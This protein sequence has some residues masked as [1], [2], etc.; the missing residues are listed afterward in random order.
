MSGLATAVE[1]FGWVALFFTI[2]VPASLA[3][4]WAGEFVTN[5]QIV[6]VGRGLFASVPVC[7]VGIALMRVANRVHPKPESR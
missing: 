7:I 3:G 6:A 2:G 1:L 4:Q 5:D